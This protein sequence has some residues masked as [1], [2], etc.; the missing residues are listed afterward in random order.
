MVTEING[1]FPQHTCGYVD[2][3]AYRKV[4][5]CTNVMKRATDGQKLQYIDR[6]I[7]RYMDRYNYI[8]YILLSWILYKSY[9]DF[10]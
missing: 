7:Y 9:Q 5:T 10:F 4:G 2:G 8:P 6:Y 3:W 1:F